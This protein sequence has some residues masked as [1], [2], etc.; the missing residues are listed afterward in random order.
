MAHGVSLRHARLR[1]GCYVVARLRPLLLCSV[2]D[3]PWG[4]ARRQILAENKETGM[5][6]GEDAAAEYDEADT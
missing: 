4:V 3:I 5:Q 2:L 6:A 1:P